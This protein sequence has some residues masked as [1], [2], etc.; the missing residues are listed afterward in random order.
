MNIIRWSSIEVYD[1]R[2]SRSRSLSLSLS[3]STSFVVVV[4]I[5]VVVVSVLYNTKTKILQR[6]ITESIL[7]I[8]NIPQHYISVLFRDKNLSECSVAAPFIVVIL[9]PWNI[10]RDEMNINKFIAVYY[11][12]RCIRDIWSILNKERTK[13]R[14]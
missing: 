13:E 11:P 7:I 8:L 5:V 1:T 3:L 2:F 6:R 12:I 14:N 9:L 4:V 10:I